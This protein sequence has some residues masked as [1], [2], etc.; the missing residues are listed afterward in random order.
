MTRRDE[1]P[2]TFSGAH[3]RVEDVANA[4]RTGGGD[5][6][7]LLVAGHGRNVT[8]PLAARYAD[9]INIDAAVD[10]MADAIGAVRGRC[11]EIGRDPATLRMATG[12]NPAWPYPGLRVTGGNG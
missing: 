1:A 2:F 10:E 12:T 3:A 8:F 5:H 6:I 11:D 7:R 9:E 4:P